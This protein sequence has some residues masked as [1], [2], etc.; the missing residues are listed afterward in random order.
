MEDLNV[1]S[2]VEQPTEWCAGMVVVPKPNGQVRIC[3]DLTKLN[4]SVCRERHILP[5]VE[6][7]LAQI[8][9][10]RIF[11][12]WMLIPDSGRWNSPATL[13]CSQLS[14]PSLGGTVLIDCPLVSPPLQSTYREGWAI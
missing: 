1:I 7:T 6:Q 9:A 11:Q 5:S 12:S 3:V 14:L 13:P 10:A 2:K 4:E 8:G